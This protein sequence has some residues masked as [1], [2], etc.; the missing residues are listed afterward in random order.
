MSISK[1]S[2][3]G[4]FAI[5]LMT[6]SAHAFTIPTMPAIP[7]MPTLP[8]LPTMPTI[9]TTPGGTMTRPVIVLPRAPVAPS[10]R[11]GVR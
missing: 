10:W 11:R 9:N 2:A 8:T 1:K 7:R 4:F 3:L 5:A 6:T